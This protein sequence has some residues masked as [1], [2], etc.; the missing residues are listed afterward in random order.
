MTIE[1]KRNKIKEYCSKQDS[2]EECVLNEFTERN[3]TDKIKEV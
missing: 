3:K 1:E 2:C